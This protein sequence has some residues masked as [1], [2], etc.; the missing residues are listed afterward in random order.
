MPPHPFVKLTKP[1]FDEALADMR[2]LGLDPDSCDD[3]KLYALLVVRDRKLLHGM[4]SP[5]DDEVVEISKTAHER[6]MHVAGPMVRVIAKL[7]EVEEDYLKIKEPCQRDVLE[8]AIALLSLL[9]DGLVGFR[10]S[11]LG[12][13]SLDDQ[14]QP[15]APPSTKHARTALGTGAGTPRNTKRETG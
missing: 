6:L 8:H 2:R 14:A 13:S 9:D 12:A 1:Y 3:W 7:K 4:P 5:D 11:P 15:K 10:V